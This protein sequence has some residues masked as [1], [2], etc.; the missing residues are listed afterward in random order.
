MSTRDRSSNYRTPE[1][2]GFGHASEELVRLAELSEKSGAVKTFQIE[3]NT[4]KM[5]FPTYKNSSNGSGEWAHAIAPTGS[6]Q[7]VVAC[8]RTGDM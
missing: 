2:F 8:V 6:F 4:C 1:A 5:G 7:E 3:A